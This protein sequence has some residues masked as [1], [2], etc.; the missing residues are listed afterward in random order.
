MTFSV[1][2]NVHVRCE[3]CC[4]CVGYQ[5]NASIAFAKHHGITYEAV[6]LLLYT[7]RN[8]RISTDMHNHSS[9]FLRLKETSHA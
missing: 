7:S 9:H 1:S 4:L 3:Q 8:H 5:Q 2:S 6:R